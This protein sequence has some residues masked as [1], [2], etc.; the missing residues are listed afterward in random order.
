M[1]KEA[2]SALIDIWLSFTGL[3]PISSLV[4]FAAMPLW[5]YAAYYFITGQW[6]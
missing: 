6:R 3:D 5:I 4:L 2:V 1:I